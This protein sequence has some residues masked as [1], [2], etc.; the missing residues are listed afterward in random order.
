MTASIALI[1]STS[2][3]IT[4][5]PIPCARDGEPAP[6]PAV[7]GHNHFRP[8]NQD[9]GGAE[10]TI[11]RRLPGAVAVVEEMLG[12]G[13]VDRDDR[14]LQAPSSGHRSQANHA[15]GGLF[16]AADNIRRS[17]PAGRNEASKPGRRRHPS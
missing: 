8:G 9:I 13:I 1:G 3:T 6:A 14:K 11:N 16:R 7:T 15:G 5:A 10:N 12:L 17:V 2:V 4:L